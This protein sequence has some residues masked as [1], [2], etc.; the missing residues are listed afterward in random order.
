M[1][2]KSIAESEVGF[3]ATNSTFCENLKLWKIDAIPLRDK[4]EKLNWRLSEALNPDANNAHEAGLERTLENFLNSKLDEKE[5]ARMG[6]ERMQ[7]VI[8][9]DQL[10]LDLLVN[11]Q[12]TLLGDLND[13]QA[14]YAS[15]E[16]DQ[17]RQ[18]HQ[19]LSI[20]QQIE[21]GE[22]EL[23]SLN[24]KFVA[25]KER[26]ATVVK[27][28]CPYCTKYFKSLYFLETHLVRKHAEELARERKEDI[29]RDRIT[30]AIEVE[31]NKQEQLTKRKELVAKLGLRNQKVEDF[32][33]STEI[34]SMLT[35]LRNFDTEMSEEFTEAKDRRQ[36]LLQ[37]HEELIAKL[38]RLES[39]VSSNNVELST[40]KAELID[41]ENEIKK[42]KEEQSLKESQKLQGQRQKTLSASKNSAGTI[43]YR[44]NSIGKEPSAETPR[45]SLENEFVVKKCSDNVIGLIKQG[46]IQAEKK[47]FFLERSLDHWDRISQPPPVVANIV[48]RVLEQRLIDTECPVGDRLNQTTS[49]YAVNLITRSLQDNR[50]ILTGA[51]FAADLEKKAKS[52][53]QVSPSVPEVTQT[54][55]DRIF[56]G[57]SDS[58]VNIV[59]DH[60]GEP[61][62]SA[63]N[64]KTLD[65]TKLS[66]AEKI[67][68]RQE[69]IKT[70]LAT[71]EAS[72]PLAGSQLQKQ[73]KIP[74]LEEPEI[75]DAL[76]PHIKNLLDVSLNQEAT[77]HPHRL[78]ME[79]SWMLRG[80]IGPNNRERNIA[81]NILFKKNTA[82]LHEFGT[83][84]IGFSNFNN[85]E[86]MDF[87][88]RLTAS[89]DAAIQAEYELFKSNLVNYPLYTFPSDLLKNAG[90]K[91]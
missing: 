5:L 28:G 24:Q 64:M 2:A 9:L 82:I 12:N 76:L 7:K 67:K 91:S 15:L 78:E 79:S 70:T 54:L 74:K 68:M 38:N 33:E 65:L 77:L 36:K 42:Q 80:D 20:F 14:S 83:D 86:L 87:W 22:A 34:Q 4:N 1:N 50:F 57:A 48:I 29:E 81:K 49:S 31:I 21:Q 52:Q 25:V 53:P 23:A 59:A 71:S 55:A 10:T 41:T 69:F 13:L 30:K 6:D 84:I 18:E 63:P 88:K 8:I 61:Q 32:D 43:R 46:L 39:K 89:N 72:L 62:S 60:A 51:E 73:T 45:E 16:K 17:E 85:S 44:D 11:V 90:R 47:V 35:T 40:I 75:K 19:G 26:Q 27:V 37:S 66:E 56:G 3:G 58:K